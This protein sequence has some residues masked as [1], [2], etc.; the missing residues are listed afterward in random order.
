MHRADGPSPETLDLLK[1]VLE[2]MDTPSRLDTHPWVDSPIVAEERKRVPGL[3]TKPPGLQLVITIVALFQRMMPTHPPR[4]G[5]RLDVRWGEFGL[6]AARYFVPFLFG[7]PYPDSLREAWQNIDHAI[8]LLVCGQEDKPISDPESYRLISKELAVAPNSTISDWHRRGLERLALLI[9][10]EEARLKNLSLTREERR[11]EKP[12]WFSR[13]VRWAVRLVIL[14]LL[15]LLG[16]GGWQGWQVYQVARR[17]QQRVENLGK[18]VPLSLNTLSFQVDAISQDVHGLRTD[19]IAIRDKVAC[20]LPLTPYLGWVP[21]YGGDIQQAS[22]LLELGIQL[23]TAADEML[24][25]LK[26]VLPVLGDKSSPPSLSE[27]ISSVGKENARLVVAQIALA[28]AKTVREQIH[29]QRLSFRLRRVLGKVDSVLAW[30]GDDMSSDWFTL[31]RLAPRL[32]GAVGNGPQRYLILLQNEDEL[33]PTGGFI[34]AVGQIVLENGNV[35]ILNFE[36]SD[37]VDDLNKPYPASPWQLR[38]YMRSEIFLLRDANWFVDFPTT[39]K[40]VKFLYSYTRPGPISGVITMDQYALAEILRVLGT[41]QVEG[42]TISA[43]NVLEY[44]RSEREVLLLV[45]QTAQAGQHRVERIERKGFIGDLAHPLMKKIVSFREYNVPDLLNVLLSLLDEKHIL[46]YFEDPEMQSFVSQHHWDG[47]VRPPEKSDFLMVIDTNVGFNKTNLLVKRTIT[48]QVDLRDVEHPVA[49]LNISYTNHTPIPIECYQIPSSV[50]IYVKQPNSYPMYDCYWNYLRVY[51]A[52]NSELLAA[53]PR[54]IP[55]G[56]TLDEMPVPAQ[57][58]LLGN[59]GIPGVTAFGGLLVI[60][61]GE[62]FDM[63]FDFRLP[64]DIVHLFS[65]GEWEYHLFVQKQPGTFNVPFYFKLI[66]PEGAEILSSSPS[67][68]KT[69]NDSLFLASTLNKDLYLTVHFSVSP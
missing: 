11:R 14:G 48:Y 13:S 3:E 66:L 24:E 16:W 7:L 37:G 47:A 30:L 45:Q 28:R 8:Q 27:L 62:T 5:K 23:S 52:E 63:R 32:L 54:E 53:T 65:P 39:V 2:N 59:D 6:L 46:L 68:I 18:V 17:L 55:A 51:V 1:I 67:S 42:K 20:L 33:R 9:E 69:D 41:V 21:V 64:R 15:F 35:I 49:H 50:G 29:D 19:L 36:S 12:V 22:Y 58:D 44:L 60:S 43:D 61:P 38:R 56:R 10:K 31:G 34:T 57:I 40:W 26:P 25:I 4:R